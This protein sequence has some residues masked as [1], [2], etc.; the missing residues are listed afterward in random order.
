[1]SEETTGTSQL[2]STP[3]MPIKVSKNLATNSWRLHVFDEAGS[4][5]P[6]EIIDLLTRISQ[7]VELID[8]N[9]GEIVNDPGPTANIPS[10]GSTSHTYTVPDGKK[11]YL[12]QVHSTS[13]VPY[14][15]ALQIDGV[16]TYF[17]MGLGNTVGE[18]S[19]RKPVIFTGPAT[20]TVTR[21]N[22]APATPP[23]PASIYTVINGVLVDS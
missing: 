23:N 7:S 13:G 14:K 8:E 16:D 21:M 10:Q 1:M 18:I 19:P 3:G 20:V 17:A 15:V 9:V 2:F 22:R 6:Q 12:W 4:T 5:G 11:F